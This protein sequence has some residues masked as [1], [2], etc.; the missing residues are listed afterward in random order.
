MFNFVQD[1]RIQNFLFLSKHIGTWGFIP[2]FRL[3]VR[4]NKK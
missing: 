1:V 4:L 3:V 2:S